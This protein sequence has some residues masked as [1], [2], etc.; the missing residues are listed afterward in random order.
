MRLNRHALLAGAALVLSTGMAWATNATAKLTADN[1]FWLYIGNAAGTNLQYIGEGHNWPTAYS[2][3]FTVAPGDYLYVLGNDGG[4]PKSWEGTFTTPQG[5]LQSNATQWVGSAVA[6]GTSVVTQALVA[7]A[8]WSAP[9]LSNYPWGNVVGDANAKWIWMVDQYSGPQ[10]ALFR[11]AEAVMAV[12]EPGIQVL[13][14]GG[15]G[16]LAVMARRR[17]PAAA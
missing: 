12:P 16:V 2:F 5:P 7:G 1:E 14:L 17:Q 13:L 15:L 4:P 6:N 9:T 3:S 10:T 11:S 8:T